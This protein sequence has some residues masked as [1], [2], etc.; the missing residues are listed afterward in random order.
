MTEKQVRLSWN[1]PNDINNYTYSWGSFDQWIYDDILSASGAIY[2]YF[3]NGK[4]ES[5]QDF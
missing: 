5:W 3:K 1:D 4:L 2:L